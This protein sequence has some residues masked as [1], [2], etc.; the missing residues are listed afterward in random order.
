MRLTFGDAPWFVHSYPMDKMYLMKHGIQVPISLCQ[1]SFNNVEK[2]VQ[3]LKP[4][5]SQVFKM[6]LFGESI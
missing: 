4:K 3:S 2:E 5:I 1:G 6:I